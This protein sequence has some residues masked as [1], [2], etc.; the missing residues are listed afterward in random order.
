VY[1]EIVNVTAKLVVPCLKITREVD[2]IKGLENVIVVAAVRA[3]G[4]PDAPMST[5]PPFAR[6]AEIAVPTAMVWTAW[7]N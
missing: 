1:P 4:T 3:P 2:P 5:V 7:D 6:F